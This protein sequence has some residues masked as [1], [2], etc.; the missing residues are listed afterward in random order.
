MKMECSNKAMRIGI[1]CKQYEFECP[2]G[3]VWIGPQNCECPM[4]CETVGITAK[5][6]EIKQPKEFNRK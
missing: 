4:C 2:C 3:Y 6:Y 1:E 5:Q